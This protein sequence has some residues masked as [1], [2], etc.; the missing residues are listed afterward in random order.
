MFF[1]GFPYACYA[2]RP[3]IRRELKARVGK[4]KKHGHHVWVW[5]RGGLLRGSGT[6]ALVLSENPSNS[7]R[8]T[9]C[10]LCNLVASPLLV[11]VETHLMKK[12]ELWTKRH[13]FFNW[14]SKS[15][16]IWCPLHPLKLR[17]PPFDS[18]TVRVFMVRQAA[19]AWRKHMYR[20]CQVVARHWSIR[21]LCTSMIFQAN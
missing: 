5:K 8:T 6:I 14:T 4:H 10:Y 17:T 2:F 13:D 15:D 19:V 1:V 16:T 21:I 3:T 11:T 12:W 18:S 7:A 9:R 20:S